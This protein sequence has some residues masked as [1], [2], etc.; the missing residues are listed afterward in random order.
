M[1][2]RGSL[3][4]HLRAR[5]RERAFPT[6]S[7]LGFLA[8][9]TVPGGCSQ[10][11]VNC[12]PATLTVAVGSTL[13]RV[14]PSNEFRIHAPGA[15]G[16]ARGRICA[17]TDGPAQAKSITRIIQRDEDGVHV[18]ALT[19]RTHPDPDR[20]RRLAIE[21]SR[22]DRSSVVRDGS[23]WRRPGDFRLVQIAALEPASRGRPG[24]DLVHCTANTITTVF[25]KDMGYPCTAVRALSSDVRGSI[26]FYA[27]SV[28]EV[29][30]GKV[31]AVFDAS[32]QD[33]DGAGAPGTP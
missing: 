8:L 13:W 30:I 7:L 19:I 12:R 15:P 5:T 21:E 16:D 20:G 10:A 22:G 6:L 25:G 27:L 24:F 1:D 4:R 2:V 14:P 26:V 29:A 18:S 23:V 28:D 31:R 17:S 11:E 3:D 9:S 33:L 32:L